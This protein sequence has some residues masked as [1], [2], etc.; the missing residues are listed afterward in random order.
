M[1]PVRPSMKKASWRS[2][3]YER[4]SSRLHRHLRYGLR[5][6]LLQGF[7][8]ALESSRQ[9]EGAATVS[10]LSTL[11][12]LWKGIALAAVVGVTV[13]ACVVRDRSLHNAGRAEALAEVEAANKEM[14][15]AARKA[16]AR[17]R[18]CV[19]GGGVWDQSTGQCSGGL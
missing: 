13:T 10:M 17:R 7:R 1:V 8:V 16:I 5:R 12:L 9:E 6:L 18:A 14:A 15:D 19:D 4:I 2:K 11:P 3:D